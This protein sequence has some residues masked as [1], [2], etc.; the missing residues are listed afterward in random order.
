MSVDYS[1]QRSYGKLY[2][3]VILFMGGGGESRF[4]GVSLSRGVSVQGVSAQGGSL[5][6]GY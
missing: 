1:P 2:L 4:P 6:R 3:S 5:S